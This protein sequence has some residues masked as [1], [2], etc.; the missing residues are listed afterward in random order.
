[1]SHVN[2]TRAQIEAFERDTP[3]DASIVML[4]L[5]RFRERADYGAGSAEPGASG[6]EAYARYSRG[7]MPLLLEVG[8]RPLWMGRARAS[9]IAPADETWDEVLLVYYPSRRAFL[10]MVKSPAYQAVM[11]HRTAAIADSRLVETRPSRLPSALLRVAGR[12]LRL[13]ALVWPAIRG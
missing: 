12:A 7:V 3:D 5:L 8:G 13:K 2:P 10:R 9:V 11:H 1:M 4:N 6:R